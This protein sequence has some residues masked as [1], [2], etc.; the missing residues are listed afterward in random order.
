MNS[1]VIKPDQLSREDFN[2]WYCDEHIHDVVAKSGVSKAHRYEHVADGSSPSRRLGFLTIYE[3]PDIN[4]IETKEFR[5]LEGQSPGP[6]KE[7]I[8]EK[9]EFDT[10]SYE[11]VQVDEAEDPENSGEIFQMA[12]WSLSLNLNAGPAPLLLCAAMSHSNDSE[13][14]AWYRGEHI[15]LIA[16]CPGYRRTSRYR[17]ATRSILSA[18]E[19][20]FPPAPTW[21]ALH[22]FNGPHIPWEDLA[23]TDETEW[24]KKVIPGIVDIDFGCFRLERVYHK[25]GR[26]KL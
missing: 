2:N 11:L 14:D 5:S 13:L 12:E 9:S 25:L 10:R 1:D 3:M 7:K 6:S 15:A 23:A 19:R 24:A 21:L 26:T 20:S 17:L 16:R 18:F 4:F 22:E 8:F